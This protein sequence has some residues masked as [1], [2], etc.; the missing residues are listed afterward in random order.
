MK[1]KKILLIVLILLILLALGL[2]IYSIINTI[3]MS[4]TSIIQLKDNEEGKEISISITK[5]EKICT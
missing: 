2:G 3:Q 1:I 4:R 5:G